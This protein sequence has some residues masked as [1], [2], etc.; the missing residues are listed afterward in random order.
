MIVTHLGG[1]QGG[2]DLGRLEDGGAHVHTHLAIALYSRLHH[3]C[4]G[5]AA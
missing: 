1:W 2:R 5:T 3:P 4:D